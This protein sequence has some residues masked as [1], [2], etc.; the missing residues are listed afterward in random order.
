[1][2][3]IN[4]NKV[5]LTFPEI[6][7]TVQSSHTYQHALSFVWHLSTSILVQPVDE[8]EV[9]CSADRYILGQPYG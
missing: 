1:M 7:N 4:E 8:N 2:N 3:F 6:K 9:A 5:Q